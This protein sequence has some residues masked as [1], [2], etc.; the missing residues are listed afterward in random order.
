[1][2]VQVHSSAPIFKKRD[3][4][5]YL[6]TKSEYDKLHNNQAVGEIQAAMS[7]LCFK[8]LKD[9]KLDP[10]VY[11]GGLTERQTCLKCPLSGVCVMKNTDDILKVL[12]SK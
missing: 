5:Q 9:M 4:V 2:V 3:I 8:Y 7:I 6:L 11:M 10:C 1:M 12:D